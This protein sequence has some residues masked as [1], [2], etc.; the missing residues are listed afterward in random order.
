M[1]NALFKLVEK[2]FIVWG[3]ALHAKIISFGGISQQSIKK[4]FS[5]DESLR[6]LVEMWL[7]AV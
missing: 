3:K 5:N 7:G 1:I 2:G 4:Q 6:Q